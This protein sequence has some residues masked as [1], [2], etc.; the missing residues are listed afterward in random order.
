[1]LCTAGTSMRAVTVA[2]SGAVQC[3]RTS[4]PMATRTAARNVRL[5]STLPQQ[6]K[7]AINNASH[8]APGGVP[9]HITAGF[10]GG[11]VAVGGGYLWYSWSGTKAVVDTLRTGIDTFESAK[12]TVKD[13]ASKASEKAPS[14]KSALDFVRA[15]ANTYSAFLPAEARESVD[16]AFDSL[17]SLIAAGSPH[18]DELNKLVGDTYGE[19]RVVFADGA[20]DAPT[21]VKVQHIIED[22]SQAVRR[23]LGDVGQ[24]ILDKNPKLNEWLKSTGDSAALNELKKVAEDAGGEGKDILTSTY[25]ELNELLKGGKA[26]DP[27]TL[28]KAAGIIRDK[29][30]QARELG[31]KS[32]EKAWEEAYENFTEAGGLLEALPEDVQKMLKENAEP[33]KKAVLASGTGGAV[34]ET[35]GMLRKYAT[36]GD[37]DGAKKVK[38]YLEKKI[39]DASDSGTTNSLLNDKT[40]DKA[41][42]VLEEY[43]KSIPGGEEFLKNTPQL[44]D[45]LEIANTSKSPEARKLAEDTVEEL[46]QVLNKRVEQA[47]KLL[48]KNQKT[49]AKH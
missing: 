4:R 43:V 36:S 27:A 3:L 35:F 21:A 19:L 2:R 5:Q 9:P 23:L 13:T 33:L 41:S 1:M 20:F 47:K 31:K 37:K 46:G 45:L 17:D 38:A 10:V 48:D 40:F 22:K 34:Y 18:A 28:Y 24:D 49:G 32:A 44:K 11:L 29:T 7:S 42:K 30:N 15:T 26:T 16:N 8:K 6:A 14:A 39:K 25:S 12:S